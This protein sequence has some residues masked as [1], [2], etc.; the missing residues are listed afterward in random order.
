MVRLLRS[1]SA[2]VGLSHRSAAPHVLRR[3]L[4]TIAL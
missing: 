1:H 3:R 2:L 4:V